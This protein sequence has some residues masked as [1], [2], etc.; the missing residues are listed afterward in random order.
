[1]IYINFHAPINPKTAQELMK[2][3]A[4][5][6]NR[7]EKQLYVLISS[8][9]GA[10]NNGVTLYNF[11]KSLPVKIIMHNVGMVDSIANVVFLAGTERYAVPN[12]SFLF[13]GVGLDITQ[14]TRLEMKQLR[15][16][17]TGIERDMRIIGEI[18]TAK[19]KLSPQEVNNMFFEAQTKT[20]QEAKEKG[21]IDDIRDVK[22][23]NTD[24]ITPLVF[25]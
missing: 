21:I 2:V 9:G 10:V 4:E 1:M 12:S 7:G 25:V 11:I 19:T 17:I 5:L 8:Q 24:T 13:H 6:V 15:E 14:P 22:I 23:Q 16:C 18:M 20:P 3:L